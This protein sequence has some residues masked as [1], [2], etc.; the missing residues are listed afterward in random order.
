MKKIT[1][2][3][4]LLIISLTTLFAQQWSVVSEPELKTLNDIFMIDA[5]EGWLVGKEGSIYHTTDGF[6]NFEMQISGVEDELSKVFFIDK[7][8]GWIGS[9]GGQ[10]LKTIDGGT[11]WEVIDLAP[12]MPAGFAFSYFNAMTFTNSSTGFVVTGKYKNIYLLK[13]TDGGT[14]W[15]AKDSLVSATSQKW[16]DIQFYDENKG[17]IVGDKKETQKYTT[18]GGETWTPGDSTL[19]TAISLSNVRW[20]NETDLICLGGGNSFQMVPLPVNKSTDGGKTWTS[21]TDV[22]NPVYDRVQDV[23][24]KD[25]MNGIAMGNNG[26]SKMFVYKTDDGGTT[27]TASMGEYSFGI[28]AIAGQGDIIY[29]L[30]TGSHI[31]K[32]TDF[33]STWTLF[34]IKGPATVNDIVFTENKGFAISKNSD[35]YVNDDGKGTNWEY[36]SSCNIWDAGVMHFINDNVGIVVKENRHIVKTVDGG[37]TWNTVL[38]P[39]EFST[40]NKVGDITFVDDQIGYVLISLNDYKEYHVLKTVN[41]GDSWE[42]IDTL[43]A[44]GSFSGGMIFFDENNGVIAGP[45]IKIDDVYTFWIKITADGGLTWEDAAI[46]NYPE[47][48]DVASLNST[49]KIDDNTA[50]AVGKKALLKT[51]DK[52]KTWE[53]IDHGVADIDTNF[54]RV[55]G[56]AD[57]CVIGLNDGSLMM[58]D[59]SGQTWTIDEIYKDAYNYKSVAFDNDGNPVLST[60]DGYILR[61]DLLTDVED[62]DAEGMVNDYS[63][64]QN[65]PNPFNPSTNITF[66]LK[67]ENKV[68]LAVYNIIGQKVF[69]LVN[70]NYEAGNHTV[71][72]DASELTSGIYFYTMKVGSYSISKK[73]L[74]LK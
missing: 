63:L 67:N 27:W 17:V 5:N 1:M 11:T 37:L 60:L 14:T 65:Y 74:L 48:F 49:V 71:K 42:D 30:G 23:Y 20:L 69:T 39:V 47:T 12:F 41:A 13:T 34:P 54:A 33:G 6:Q 44:G 24:F 51:S 64:E 9:K 72:F 22:V 29:A 57:V 2:V 68:E 52:G 4:S 50:L 55:G 73:M 15:A 38:D 19:M 18:D 21:I 56:M 45:R 70:R 10:V 40:K 31:V 8:I 28:G 3:L 25:S 26:F 61:N 35:V 16:Y 62:F 36:L 46:N 58:S 53:Y 7:N 32:S 66:S 43:A 59:D